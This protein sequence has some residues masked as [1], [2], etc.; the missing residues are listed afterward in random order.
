[1]LSLAFVIASL[2]RDSAVSV[3]STLRQATKKL[4][5]GSERD[6]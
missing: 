2:K 3:L 1:M 5:T 6:T 4:S